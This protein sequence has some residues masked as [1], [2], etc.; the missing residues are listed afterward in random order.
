MSDVLSEIKNHLEYLGYE[1][2][3]ASDS[4]GIAAKHPRH[5]TMLLCENLSAI[6]H[7]SLWKIEN[8]PS[9]DDVTFLSGLNELNNAAAVSTYVLSGDALRIDASYCGEYSKLKSGAFLD[10][11]TFDNSDGLLRND[12]IKTYL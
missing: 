10:A 4:E 12:K 11:F 3:A 1:I 5:G 9:K 2:E 8:A 6:L 7:Q